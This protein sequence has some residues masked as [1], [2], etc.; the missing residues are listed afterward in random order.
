MHIK[1]KPNTTKP[2]GGLEK[3][4]GGLEHGSR[5]VAIAED[6]GLVPSIY[7]MTHGHPQL[8]FQGIL[9]LF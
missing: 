1:T 8:K 3:C 7:M 2:H 4:L 9:C 5:F 6:T